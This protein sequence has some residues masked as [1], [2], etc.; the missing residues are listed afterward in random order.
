MKRNRNTKIKLAGRILG[1]NRL[2]NLFQIRAILLV[3]LF[4]VGR[5]ALQVSGKC[6]F[7]S[8]SSQITF[9]GANADLSSMEQAVLCPQASK[10]IEY[11]LSTKNNLTDL[12]SYLDLNF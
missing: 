5:T 8:L 6:G 1:G 10:S 11:Y 9:Q 4:Q 3:L 12:I 7:D 2:N